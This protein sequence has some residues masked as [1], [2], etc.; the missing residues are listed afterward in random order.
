[1]GDPPCRRRRTV[2]VPIAVGLFAVLATVLATSTQPSFAAAP[3]S[4]PVRT[5]DGVDPSRVVYGDDPSQV[6]DLWLPADPHTN[7]DVD[8]DVAGVAAVPVVVLVHGGFWRTTYGLELM[9]PLAADLVAR[10]VAV[11]NVEYRRVGHEGG[12]WPGTLTDVA[13]AVDHLAVLADE[14]HLDL[15]DVSIVGHSAGGHLA[16]WVSG[17]SA[18]GADQPG[19]EPIVV[20]HTAIGQAPVADLV[21]A[22]RDGIGSGAVANLLGGGPDDVPERYAHATPRFVEGVDVV[23]VRGDDDDIVPAEYTLPP[24]ATA[25][26]LPPGSADQSLTVVDVPGE[27]HFDL[28]DPK[29]DSWAAVIDALGLGGG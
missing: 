5:V 24:G 12:G 13:D 6:G 1:M 27:D 25:D 15:G 26:T 18:L 16:L 19:A 22:E 11:W 4:E 14:H 2:P 8:V 9:D 17:R 23:V 7:N 3:A 28:I 10:G 21:R 20:P 29:S